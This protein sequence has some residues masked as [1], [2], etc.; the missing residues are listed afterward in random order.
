MKYRHITII[1]DAIQIV[2]KQKKYLFGLIGSIIVIF[3]LF[4]LIPV[5]IV[6]GNDIPFQL[7]I[8]PKKDFI[9]L[10]LLAII[11]GV[12]L[13]FHLYIMRRKKAQSNKTTGLYNN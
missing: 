9:I 6:P 11:T 3:W 13:L 7:S 4:I 10:L 8:M 12:T 1:W 5:I 2:F